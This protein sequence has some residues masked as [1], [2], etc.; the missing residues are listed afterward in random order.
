M[1]IETSFSKTW[2]R[3]ARF[4]EAPTPSEH[5]SADRPDHQSEAPAFQW[6]RFNPD[7]PADRVPI[8]N[9]AVSVLEDAGQ[10]DMEKQRAIGALNRI[11]YGWDRTLNARENLIA[12]KGA[13]QHEK[14]RERDRQERMANT[15]AFQTYYRENIARMP[16]T[17]TPTRT[18]NVST[19]G[20][21]TYRTAPQAAVRQA[22]ERT[23]PAKRGFFSKIA[24][25]F[26][27]R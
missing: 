20:P 13:I 5:A 23:A 6:Q 25:L 11:G 8:L 12:L 4:K 10:S 22:Q 3:P 27:R 9:A 16:P 26:R 15:E 19:E 21:A 2:Q 7:E 18:A 14:K 17:E 1:P 24:G